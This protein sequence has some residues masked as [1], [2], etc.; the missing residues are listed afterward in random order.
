MIRKTE[1]KD[2]GYILYIWTKLFLE[3][4]NSIDQDRWLEATKSE[5]DSHRENKTSVTL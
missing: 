3:A 4:I 5:L 1:P 2:T